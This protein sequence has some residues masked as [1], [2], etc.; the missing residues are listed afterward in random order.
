MSSNET[1][2]KDEDGNV[3]WRR[4]VKRIGSLKTTPTPIPLDI[5][6]VAENAT[7]SIE[8]FANHNN[9]LERGG[10]LGFYVATG[11]QEGGQIRSQKL[12]KLQP[13]PDKK[14]PDGFLKVTIGRSAS[15]R[16]NV[17]IFIENDWPESEMFNLT[18][19]VEGY[20]P[21][22]SDSLLS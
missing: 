3:I 20:I 1:T 19:I 4:I 8:V 17:R 22:V 21:I 18:V 9:Q 6:P 2:I 14:I 13:D 16:G 5:S 10:W 11:N 12:V 7:Y 15:S